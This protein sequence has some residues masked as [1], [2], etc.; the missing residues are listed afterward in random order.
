VTSSLPSIVP[1]WVAAII[2]A[3]LVGTLSHPSGIYGW[4][5]IVLVVSVL[6]TFIIQLAL[7]TK[8]GLVER[9]AASI[10]GA[11]I[12]LAVATGVLVLVGA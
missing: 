6:L 5:S 3:V 7:P 4:L 11:V 12:L 9:T 10:G 2:G 1:V 8:E